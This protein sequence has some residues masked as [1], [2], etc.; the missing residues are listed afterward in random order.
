MARFAT[1]VTV[2]TTLDEHGDLHG[3]TANAFTSV[4]LAPPTV[5]VCV[6]HRTHTYNFVEAHKAFGINILGE[7]QK[8]IGAYFAR[9]PEDRHGDVEYSHRL[10][11][12]GLPMIEGALTYFGCHVVGSHVHGDHT[13]YVAEV[14]EVVEGESGKPLLF[15]ESR[16]AV[17]GSDS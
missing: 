3:M 7:Q 13:I 6:D 9:K 10:S 5:L 16:W 11:E 15:H 4:C 1:G 12:K 14:D 17:M 8:E 2:V